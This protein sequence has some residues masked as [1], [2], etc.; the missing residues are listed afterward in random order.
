MA[1]TVSRVER[2]RRGVRLTVAGLFAASGVLHV[3]RPS[4]FDDFMPPWVP[5]P[6]AVNLAAG[7]VELV[8]AYG[9]M[10]RRRWAGPASAVVLLAVWP[11]NLQ[12]AL[13]ATADDGITS[14][15]ALIA[16]ARMPLQI[17]MIWAVLDPM[18]DPEPVD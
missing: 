7:A 14:T 3:V 4:A 15:T 17:P 10:T 16:W 11:S 12:F 13:G 9:L 1:G 2:V 8:C 5:A 6:V 18:D